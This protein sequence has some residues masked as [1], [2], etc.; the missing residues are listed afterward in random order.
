MLADQM[1]LDPNFTPTCGSLANF[2]LSVNSDEPWNQELIFFNIVCFDNFLKAF[3]MLFQAITLEGWAFMMY[4]VMDTEN[5]LVTFIFFSMLVI[6]GSF[7]AIQL[8]L[9]EVMRNWDAEREKMA[10][11]AAEEKKNKENEGGNNSTKRNIN[12]SDDDNSDEDG[13]DSFLS[14]QSIEHSPPVK[15]NKA[16][17]EVEL[18]Q[19]VSLTE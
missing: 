12:D 6:F 1:A 2:G 8:V 3:L 7:F 4:N 10:A 9:G 11:E 13:F 17:Q 15:K 18:S 19:R 5:P 16:L 14:D